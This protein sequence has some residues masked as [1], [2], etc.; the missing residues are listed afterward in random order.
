LVEPERRPGA[1]QRGDE[2]LVVRI[3]MGIESVAD[4]SAR[5]ARLDDQHRLEA[6]PPSRA[7][8]LDGGEEFRVVPPRLPQIVANQL[9][10]HWQCLHDSELLWDRLPGT[11]PVLV[12]GQP[13]ATG[14]PTAPDGRSSAAPP[15][16]FISA[17]PTKVKP[18]HQ[19]NKRKGSKRRSLSPT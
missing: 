8:G 17:T 12:V 10:R 6:V 7:D 3:D 13:A 11:I 19:I 5:Q 2:H 16:F 4:L 15:A 14:C 9:C 18:Q 1:A